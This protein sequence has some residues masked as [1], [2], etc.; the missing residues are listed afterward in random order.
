MHD[1]WL[2][3]KGFSGLLE[4][5]GNSFC[6]WQNRLGRGKGIRYILKQVLKISLFICKLCNCTLCNMLR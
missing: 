1:V 6:L 3:L 5:T 2:E 4:A